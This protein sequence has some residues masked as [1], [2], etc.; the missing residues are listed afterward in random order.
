MKRIALINL[1]FLSQLIAFAD[2]GN[3]L[4]NFGSSWS[5]ATRGTLIAFGI[6]SVLL[7]Y[8]TFRNKSDV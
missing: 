2:S 3:D 5:G 4:D 1:F 7:A 6:V 8:R